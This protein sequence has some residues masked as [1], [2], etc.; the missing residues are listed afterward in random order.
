MKVAGDIRKGHFLLPLR[1]VMFPK[2]RKIMHP[3][4]VKISKIPQNSDIIF[5]TRTLVNLPKGFFSN[6]ELAYMSSRNKKEEQEFFTFN[7]LDHWL[8][9]CLIKD[10]AE[11][12]KRKELN[13][14]SGEK[15]GLFL[16]EQNITNS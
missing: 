16:N 2:V 11:P 9:V 8:F 14:R 6:G 3:E 5:I 10:D 4:I 15:S 1:V 13:R 12:Y 7:R